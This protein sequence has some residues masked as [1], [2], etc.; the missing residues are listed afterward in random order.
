MLI[1]VVFDI[2]FSNDDYYIGFTVERQYTSTWSSRNDAISITSKTATGF[3]V[4]YYNGQTNLTRDII[5]H[6]VCIKNK[7]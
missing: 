2:P 3:Q 5:L 6:Y 7:N 4:A 1:D